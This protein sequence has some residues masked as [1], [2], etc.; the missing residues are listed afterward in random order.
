MWGTSFF[1]SACGEQRAK[2]GL[3]SSD[4]LPGFCIGV[5]FHLVDGFDSLEL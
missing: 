5:C 3:N 2:F 1:A 4:Y